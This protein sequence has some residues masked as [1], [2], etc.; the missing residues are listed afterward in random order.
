[1]TIFLNVTKKTQKT[2]Q[3]YTSIMIFE[4]VDLSKKADLNGGEEDQEEEQLH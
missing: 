3:R 2:K 1:M 4:T